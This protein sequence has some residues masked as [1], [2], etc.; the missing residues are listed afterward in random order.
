MKIYLAGNPGSGEG[1]V[2]VRREKQI[3][4]ICKKRLLSY[5]DYLEDKAVLSFNLIKAQ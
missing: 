4:Q 5:W 2:V 3:Q 1:A